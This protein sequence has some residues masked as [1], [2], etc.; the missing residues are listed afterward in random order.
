MRNRSVKNFYPLGD[1]MDKL[2]QLLKNINGLFLLGLLCGF[3]LTHLLSKDNTAF[4][5]PMAPLVRITEPSEKNM[6]EYLYQTGNVVAS[7]SVDLVARVEGYLQAITFT[8]GTYVKKGKPLF[9]IEPEPYQEN[10]NEA[11]ANL[12][13]AIASYKHA[14]SEYLRQVKLK[15]QNATSQSDLESWLAQKDEAAAN[16]SKAKANLKTAE[17]N[18]SY[19][20]VV[21]P[22]EG[23]IG[24][25][26][27]DVGNIV[28]SGK[29]T[30]IASIEKIAP[31]YVYFNLN[32]IDILR[33]RKVAKK[34][35]RM[36]KNTPPIS[37]GIGL[38]NET[39]YPTTGTLDFINQG[40]DASTGTLQL[41]AIV[42]NEDRHLIPG[43]FVNIRI[44]IS[45]K[46]KRLTIPTNALSY[47][48]SGPFVY[49][50]NDKNLIEMRRVTLGPK[51]NDTQ[52]ISEGLKK[53]DKV[54]IGGIQFVTLGKSVRIQSETSA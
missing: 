11:K 44:P 9:L 49:V 4:E 48:Q 28:G 40:V 34:N 47:D 15:K 12:E 32:E 16:V 41:R 25:H 29:P 37:L 33:L 42:K 1:K 14:N 7:S 38:Q 21:A 27:V 2:K 10:L 50:V 36:S 35:G 51:E 18:F 5:K 22:F 20:Q 17:I 54:V 43:F 52:A 23:R 13:S 53:T 8:D 30:T 46:M 31:I 3:L 26:L 45:P 39:N 6:A 24:R 19:T